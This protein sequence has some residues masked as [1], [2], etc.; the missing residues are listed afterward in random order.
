MPATAAK[1]T[2]D[3]KRAMT[4]ARMQLLDLFP[5]IPAAEIA[6][7][8]VELDGKRWEITLSYPKP[9]PSPV[10][11]SPIYTGFEDRIYK[12]FGIDR[13]TGEVLFMRIRKP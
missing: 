13:T 3:A 2:I 11:R 4:I 1:D 8:E 7:D 10:R 5:L 6:L 12:K 9:L